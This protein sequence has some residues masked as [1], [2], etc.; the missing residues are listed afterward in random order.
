[1]WKNPFKPYD[2][3]SEEQVVKIHDQAMLILQEIGVD[4]LHPRALDAFRAAGL[5]IDDQ[6][7]RFE[8]AFIEEQ[9]RKVPPRF[10]IQARNPKNTVTIGGDYMVT[11]PVYGP[12]FITDLDRGR[13]NPTIE[14]FTNFDKMAQATP[15]IHCAGG[16]I[17]EPEN[18]PLETRHLDM[19]YSHLRWTDKPFM[20]SVIS[21]ENARDS[22]EMGLDRVRG[23]G[24]NRKDTGIAG[25][26]QCQQPTPLRRPDAGCL[27][28]VRIRQSAGDRD[29]VP[30]G[31]R[32]V[33]D[34]AR[35]N[36]RAA[37]GGGAGRHRAHPAHPA[38][39]PMYLRI[40]SD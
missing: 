29:A 31:R 1:M 27:D 28:G 35:G 11:A 13:R 32:D 3:L 7:V 5:S 39:R 16:T 8:R 26:G 24:Q 6:R 33:A 25:S 12:P 36:H 22:I 40:L 23:A 9:V 10:D 30:D 20:G 4:F 18:V 37:D 15:Q 21:E 19:V 14:D 38:R 2:I 17:V 34:G